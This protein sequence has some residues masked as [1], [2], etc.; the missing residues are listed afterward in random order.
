M[1]NI[2]LTLILC[3]SL[4]AYSQTYAKYNG[5]KESPKTT[6]RTEDEKTVEKLI[7]IANDFLNK[8]QFA[9]AAK[10]CT[11]ALAYNIDVAN[12]TYKRAMTYFFAAEHEK[13]IADFNSILPTYSKPEEIYFVRGLCKYNLQDRECA[14]EDLA[15]SRSLG[16]D[17]DPK[18]F[19]S[20]CE[21]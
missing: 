3:F 15:L 7:M 16:K 12:I 6:V 9:D 18:L 17:I 2:I 11:E 13:A 8:K 21:Q 4:T 10:Y 19:S 20:F 1:Q 14:C 5:K